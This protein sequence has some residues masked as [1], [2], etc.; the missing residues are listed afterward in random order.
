MS[1]G[2]L[3]REVD[4]LLGE[5]IMDVLIDEAVTPGQ[6]TTGHHQHDDLDG[7]AGTRELVENLA[8]HGRCS[9]RSPLS[10]KDLLSS[11]IVRA[12]GQAARSAVQSDCAFIR[13]GSVV[14]PAEPAARLA[15]LRFRIS[16]HPSGGFYAATEQGSADARRRG[17]DDSVIRNR[18]ALTRRERLMRC[19]WVEVRR[20]GS[21]VCE[22]IRANGRRDAQKLA[23][24]IRSDRYQAR[25][26]TTKRR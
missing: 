24:S 5:L 14:E 22:L 15:R 16:P 19:F 13:R 18:S 20:P 26:I 4:L 12:S 21:T 7:A 11:M 3:G 10:E 9:F 17:R 2:G 23:D 25:V 8:G 1:E 6:E